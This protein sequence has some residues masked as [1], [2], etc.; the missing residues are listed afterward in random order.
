MPWIVHRLVYSPE[1]LLPLTLM[2]AAE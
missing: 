2:V 1:K